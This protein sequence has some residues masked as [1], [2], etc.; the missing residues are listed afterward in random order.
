MEYID[1]INE[2][3]QLNAKLKELEEKYAK[4]VLKISTRLEELSQ[5][6]EDFLNGDKGF[7]YAREYINIHGCPLNFLIY[8][9]TYIAG[10]KNELTKDYKKFLTHDLE[11]QDNAYGGDWT[12]Y[13][14]LVKKGHSIDYHPN[15]FSINFSS[16]MPVQYFNELA[17]ELDRLAIQRLTKIGQVY[18]CKLFQVTSCFPTT[19]HTLEYKIKTEQYDYTKLLKLLNFPTEV[20]FRSE[21]NEVECM[22]K[23]ID[24]S[25]V[26]HAYYDGEWHNMLEE[27]E[28]FYK[29]HWSKRR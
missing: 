7:A 21:F 24:D 1:V 4:E 20:H 2:E 23:L 26:F 28:K 5:H 22:Y 15:L 8:F 18:G 14:L 3:T 6:K 17:M 12:K 29:E 16:E 25:Y 13:T 27:Y 19:C 9:N 11:L 10:L